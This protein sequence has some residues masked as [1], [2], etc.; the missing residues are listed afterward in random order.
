MKP[1]IKEIIEKKIHEATELNFRDASCLY[2]ETEVLS[3]KNEPV[4]LTIKNTKYV[5]VDYYDTLP[6]SSTLPASVSLEKSIWSFKWK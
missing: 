4:E 5:I 2:E 3:E 1:F 6:Q